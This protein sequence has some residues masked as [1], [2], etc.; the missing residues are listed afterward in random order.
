[1][2]GHATR[3]IK[4]IQELTSHLPL[5]VNGFRGNVCIPVKCN[6]FKGSYELFQ[7]I[8]Q[9]QHYCKFWWSERRAAYGYP[10]RQITGT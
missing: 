3:T 7:P 6:S 5:A 1:M 8:L 9:C 2:T 10:C 4:A